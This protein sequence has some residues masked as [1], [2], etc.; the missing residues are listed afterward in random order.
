MVVHKNNYSNIGSIKYIGKVKDVGGMWFGV[1]LDS[2]TGKND[3]STK[4]QKYFACK[5]GHGVFLKEHHFIPYKMG[6]EVPTYEEY[7]K[8][9]QATKIPL[10]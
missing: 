5:P 10:S 9:K 4:G 8:K 2:A 7:E 6:M 1:E 3:G